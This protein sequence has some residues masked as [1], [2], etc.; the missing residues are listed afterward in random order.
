[1]NIPIEKRAYEYILNKGGN[2]YIYTNSIRGCC[3]GQ[4]T[5]DMYPEI[6]LGK[7]SENDIYNYEKSKYKEATIYVHQ[8]VN[9]EMIKDQK[10][11]LKKALGMF[12]SLIFDDAKK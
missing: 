6:N 11:V 5:V 4:T 10:I 9:Q 12:N 8:K 2:I 3:G 7:P 1:M